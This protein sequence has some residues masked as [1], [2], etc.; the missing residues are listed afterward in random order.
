LTDKAIEKIFNS[1]AQAQYL[2]SLD[3]SNNSF[4]LFGTKLIFSSLRTN[5]DGPL[6][7]L[8]LDKNDLSKKDLLIQ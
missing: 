6:K 4:T 7:K 3:L 8:I 5:P 1:V 2:E